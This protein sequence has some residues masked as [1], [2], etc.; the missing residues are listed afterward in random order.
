M[1]KVSLSAVTGGARIQSLRVL[2]KNRVCILPTT[3]AASHL[4]VCYNHMS[5]FSPHRTWKKG[6]T[7]F[8]LHMTKLKP[9]I[10]KC[11]T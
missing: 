10:D 11:F 5:L 3:H 2:F 7:D 4:L 6:I 9:H 8:L 1:P